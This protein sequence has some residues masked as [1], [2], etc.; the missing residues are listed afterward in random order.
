MG[1]PQL[2]FSLN[3][4]APVLDSFYDG[5]RPAA[6]AVPQTIFPPV[7]M[8]PPSPR[9]P[10]TEP[11]F[12]DDWKSIAQD[13][14]SAKN[15]NRGLNALAR[16]SGKDEDSETGLSEEAP[17]ALRLLALAIHE[18]KGG[19]E[20][21]A[22]LRRL[23]ARISNLT[24][25]QKFAFAPKLTS[26]LTVYVALGRSRAPH[27]LD[28]RL[29]F[30]RMLRLLE[31]SGSTLTEFIKEVDP[32]LS[33]AGGF[34]LRAHSYDALLPYLNHNPSEAAALAPMLF[35][36]GRPREIRLHA[37]QLQG[38]MAQLAAP[39]KKNGALDAFVR[40]LE[41][42]AGGSSQATGRRVAAYLSVNEYLLPDRLEPSIR[43]LEETLPPG[44]L[45]DAGLI[46]PDPHDQWPKD[47]WNFVLHFASTESYSAFMARFSAQ[48]Y[49][50]E[51]SPYGLGMTKT[52]AS[53]KVVLSARLYPGDKEGFLR[54]PVAR[55]FL[56]DVEKN[57]RDPGVQG[58][59]LRNHAQFRIVNLF[60]KG[61]TPGKM[62]IDGSCRSA[63]DLRTL[64][65]K[66]PTCHFIVNTG[67]GRGRINSDAVRAIVEGLA[68]NEDWDEIWEA[69]SEH[70]PKSAARMQGPWTPPFGE[71]LDLLE[72]AEKQAAKKSK[73]TKKPA[74]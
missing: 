32:G 49:Q 68:R 57:L 2:D 13:L 63:W 44:I 56:R 38:L 69:W 26:P 6:P 39:T 34:L 60:G 25:E 62:L 3:G 52:F 42:H 35:P 17:E 65:A 23:L 20:A 72:A 43:R 50:Y 61:V 48:G 28:A 19:P 58:V 16:S 37:T 30:E 51:A 1:V 41:E 24:N 7:S 55:D 54:G 9:Q 12:A 4:A 15:A 74:A 67:T 22:E 70:N 14:W 11:G 31:G 71:A 66:C 59:I 46:P 53:L 45:E 73:M 21:P 47:H 40:G 8:P 36:E 18:G 27:S 64:R 5:L 29:Y 33:H 10:W